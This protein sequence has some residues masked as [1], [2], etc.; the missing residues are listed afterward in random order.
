MLHITW[1]CQMQP[2]PTHADTVWTSPPHCIYPGWNTSGGNLWRPTRV[3]NGWQWYKHIII[4]LVMS[5]GNVTCGTC[6]DITHPWEIETHW[7]FIKQNLRACKRTYFKHR[8]VL[9]TQFHLFIHFSFGCSYR[10][11][12]FFPL[13][14]AFIFDRRHRSLAAETPVKYGCGLSSN[15]FNTHTHTY[16]YIYIKQKISHNEKSR[17]GILYPTHGWSRHHHL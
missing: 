4:W 11:I 2:C 17:T 15:G 3:E 10:K 8:S 9:L 14:V 1:V 6:D 12:V 13:H 5:G 7:S 16:I